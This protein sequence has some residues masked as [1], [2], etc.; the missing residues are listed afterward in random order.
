MA[1]SIT[2]FKL[3]CT[4]PKLTSKRPI[5]HPWML[6]QHKQNILQQICPCI[7]IISSTTFGTTH[8]RRKSEVNHK[9]HA[10]WQIS[11]VEFFKTFADLVTPI[12]TRMFNDCMWSGFLP[13][14]T[15]CPVISTYCT[16][17]VT[18]LC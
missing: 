8:Y 2:T 7:S 5:M 18:L 9:I 13:C 17:K 15:F 3:N 10:R 1:E 16:T 11:K 4:L 6:H 14:I 12:L